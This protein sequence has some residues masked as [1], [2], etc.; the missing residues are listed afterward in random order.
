MSQAQLL[1][2]E[3]SYQTPTGQA[4][5]TNISLA[6]TREKIALVGPNGCGK[7]TLLK[8]ITG[9]LLP[10]NGIIQVACECF[11]VPQNPTLTPNTTVASVLGDTQKIAAL[12]RI[13]QGSTALEDYALLDDDWGLRLRLQ[14][15]LQRFALESL[16]LETP[17]NALSG[18]EVTR[19]LL[20]KAFA[21]NATYLLL[22]EPTN[23]LDSDARAL[24][25][26]A[27]AEWPGG[28]LIAS[29]DRQL[30]NTMSL[31]I[32]ITPHGIERYSGNY[33]DYETQKARRL[34]T[35]L[36]QHQA[37]KQHVT[38]I[39]HSIQQ[40]KEKHA[41]RQAYGERARERNDQPKVLL[42][43][44]KDRSTA[45]QKTDKLRH[46]R[47]LNA[48]TDRLEEAKAQLTLEARITVK[49]PATLVPQGKVIL[50]A[51]HLSFSY[52]NACLPRIANINLTLTG[53]MR[54][55]LVGANGSGKSTLIKLFLQQLQPQSGSVTL[56]TPH[57]QYIDQAM[58]IL[59]ASH[60]ILD[61]YLRLNPNSNSQQAHHALAQ[62]LFKNQE[63]KQLVA[64]VSG[65][66]K[67]R[68]A[69]A[70]TLLATQPPQLLI[71]DEPTNHL[72]L[73]SI[74]CIEDILNAY[75]GTLL[76]I[77]HDQTF[78]TNI[79]IQRVIYAPFTNI[80]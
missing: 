52:P 75:Q 8:L 69:L 48:A 42:D 23:H 2:H 25:Y 67:L 49:L 51:E 43:K 33:N 5:F 6:L 15:Q 1:I 78:L 19:L 11:Y 59:D 44:M 66:E 10:S 40:T 4:I 41:E 34:Q 73:Q 79:H 55:A 28:L 68:A 60:S 27:I 57:I 31:I 76:V 7:S 39:K 80:D 37:A 12:Q 16:A 14:T 29:H 35:R 54:V 46:Q 56:G 21:S 20:C 72:D 62:F 77:S 38:Q 3:M 13:E 36:A 18:G 47:M 50:R 17:V 32:D 63:A 65:G 70:C 64:H 71:L 26:Q 9:K 53:P 74:Q 61:N 30:L 58:Q 24:L 22:D 45:S